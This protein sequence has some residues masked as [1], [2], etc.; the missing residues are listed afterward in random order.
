MLFL[1]YYVT[2]YF[3]VIIFAAKSLYLRITLS[4]IKVNLKLQTDNNF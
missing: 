2:L 4:F 1:T 3:N